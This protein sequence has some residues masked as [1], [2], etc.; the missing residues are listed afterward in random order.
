MMIEK[1]REL[2]NARP[3]KAFAIHPASGRMIR[4]PYR[5]EESESIVDL[6]LVSGI[7][8]KTVSIR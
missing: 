7:N 6:F 2:R 1:I 8:L 5:A 4:A 3:F